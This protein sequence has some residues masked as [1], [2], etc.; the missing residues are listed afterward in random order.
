[1]LCLHPP[2]ILM[3]KYSLRSFAQVNEE[4]VINIKITRRLFSF[5]ELIMKFYASHSAHEVAEYLLVKK[6]G[7]IKK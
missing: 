2:C 6:I 3:Q 5:L 4:R 1:M 7:I